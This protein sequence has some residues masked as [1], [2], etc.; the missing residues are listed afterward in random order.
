MDDKKKVLIVDDDDQIATM[1]TTHLEIKGFSTKRVSNGEEALS[2]ALDFKPDIILL[3]VMMPKI[4]GF[5]VLDI[6]KNTEQ[7]KDIPVIMLTALSAT[8]DM[9]KAKKLGANEYLEKSATDLPT[10]LAKINGLIKA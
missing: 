5:D 10:I 7:T 1:Y 4:S 9:E 6:L 2:T 8:E 3:D